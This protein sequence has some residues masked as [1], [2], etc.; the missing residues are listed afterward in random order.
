MQGKRKSTG[1]RRRERRSSGAEGET[2]TP[3]LPITNRLLYQLSYLGF[4]FDCNIR[5][6]KL[7][8]EARNPWGQF[9]D[10]RVL[11]TGPLLPSP[12]AIGP[13][14]ADF[15]HSLLR[16]ARKTSRLAHDPLTQDACSGVMQ[17]GEL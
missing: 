15:G 9:H 6:K 5:A 14:S 2:R 8:N 11:Q 3:D 4:P 10:K 1:C 16:F 13:T 7:S 17:K 12:P